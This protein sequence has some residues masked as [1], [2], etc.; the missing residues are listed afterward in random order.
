ML[1]ALFIEVVCYDSGILELWKEPLAANHLRTFR[2]QYKDLKTK[3]V[4]YCW[5]SC[6]R[7]HIPHVFL[8]PGFKATPWT[9]G[10]RF[11]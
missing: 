6:I 4:K 8:C 5:T 9:V 10:T 11:L 3:H 1:S 2:S 7:L